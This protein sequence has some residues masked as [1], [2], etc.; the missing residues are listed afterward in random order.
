MENAVNISI[1]HDVFL[2]RSPQATFQ[3]GTYAHLRV[4]GPH[5]RVPPYLP[6]LPLQPCA[7]PRLGSGGEW[8]EMASGT[9]DCVVAEAA[10]CTWVSLAPS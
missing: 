2:N 5:M 9:L 4:H 6:V 1:W 10:Y 7:H 8:S 3:M